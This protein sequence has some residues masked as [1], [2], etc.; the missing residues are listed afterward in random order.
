[1][2]PF[3]INLVLAVVWQGLSGS[4]SLSSLAVGFVVGYVVMWL[5]RPLFGESRYSSQLIDVVMLVA[6]FLKELF[7]SSVRV[8]WYVLNPLARSRPGIVAVPLELCTDTEIT[9]LANLVS[10]TPGSLSID[11]SEDRRTLLVHAMFIDDPDE[12][13]HALKSGMERRVLE[14]MR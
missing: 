3:A 13:R 9:V 8:A 7:V 6:Y 4:F 5:L 1:V 14:A 11:V 10:L 12:E 2:T